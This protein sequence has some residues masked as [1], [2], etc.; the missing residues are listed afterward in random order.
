MTAS[1]SL[2]PRT[3]ASGLVA[4][5][6]GLVLVNWAVAP[7]RPRSWTVVLLFLM[8]LAV[9]SWVASRRQAQAPA[10]RQESEAIQRAVVFAAAMIAV[11][12]IGRLAMA[13]GALQDRE[14]SRQVVMLLLAAYLVAAGNV[15]PKW[16]RPLSA[17]ACDPARD[18]AVRRFAGW[19]FVLS[20]LAFAAAWLLLPSAF[21]EPV[22]IAM[23]VAGSLAVLGRAVA[24]HR[25]R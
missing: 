17:Q 15:L 23:L 14:A 7:N 25:R 5:S 2:S 21:A 9:V 10:Q 12:L 4:L 1:L 18:Q 13:A 8:G 24:A 6:A 20:G 19:T 16:G 3:L 11:P 22:S